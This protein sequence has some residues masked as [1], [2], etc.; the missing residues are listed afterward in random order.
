MTARAGTRSVRTCPGTSAG[1]PGCDAATRRR[2]GTSD[3]TLLRAV[4][5]QAV[6]S[7]ATGAVAFVAAFVVMAFLD[8]VP[9]GVTLGVIAASV[10]GRG[11]R[12]GLV[13][14]EPTERHVS[15]R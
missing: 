14:R 3:T 5:T 4:S 9:L 6:V 11:S 1:V 13:S 8:V 2:R 10:A 12:V 7:A 15:P